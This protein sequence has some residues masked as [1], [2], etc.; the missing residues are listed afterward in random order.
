MGVAVL[1]R[2]LPRES[3][4]CLAENPFG[5]DLIVRGFLGKFRVLWKRRAGNVRRAIQV[6]GQ[7]ARHEELPD[8]SRGHGLQFRTCQLRII[9][10]TPGI[11]FRL[12]FLP[13]E[14][15]EN[16]VLAVVSQLVKVP[17]RHQ[18]QLVPGEFSRNSLVDLL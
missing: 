10:I 11:R 1:P 7:R 2:G 8:F 15:L 12:F 3:L 18:V 17:E 5:V 6:R 16:P 14:E 9:C 4:P 13:R